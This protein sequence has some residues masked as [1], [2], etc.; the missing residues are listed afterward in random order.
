MGQPDFKLERIMTTKLADVLKR[1]T[2]IKLADVQHNLGL[3]A[4][5]LEECVALLDAQHEEPN[6][7]S[8]VSQRL[9]RMAQRM[10]ERERG[11]RV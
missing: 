8:I 10:R 2:A 3:E 11:E 7:I 6:N 9:G 1:I 4:D 5:I